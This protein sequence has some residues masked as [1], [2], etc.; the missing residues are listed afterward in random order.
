MYSQ[1]LYSNTK[2]AKAQTKPK[3]VIWPFYEFELRSQS[4]GDCMFVRVGS[5]QSLNVQSLV[6]SIYLYT[7]NNK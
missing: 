6:P 7:I 4:F 5:L 2:K 3:Q 1:A